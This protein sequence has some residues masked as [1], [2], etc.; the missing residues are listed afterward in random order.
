MTRPH[1]HVA[2]ASLNQTVGD[3]RGNAAR[4]V[5]A[6]DEAR[7]RGARLLVLPELCVSGYSLGDRVLRHGTLDQSWNTVEML[8]SHTTGM[9][10][11]VGLPVRHRGVLYNAVAVLA[12]GEIAGLAAKENLATGDV[13]YENRWYAGWPRGQVDT[14]TAPDGSPIPMGALVFDAPGLGRFAIEVCEDAWRGNRPASIY[15]L[16]GAEILINPSASW[17]VVGKHAARRR[18]VEQ[19]SAEDHAAYVFASLRGCDA[20]RLVFDGSVFI[21]IDGAIEQEA[22]RFRFGPGPTLIDRVIDL[23][24]LAKRRM[25]A[26]SWRQQ[27]DALHTGQLGTPPPT[28]LQVSGDYS[29][30]AP[31][32]PSPP[33]WVA[34]AAHVDPSLDWLHAEGMV[35]RP[36]EHADIPHIE[37]ELALATGLRD[38]LAKSGVKRVAL[39][40]SGGRD[41]TMVA[42]LVHRMLR[43]DNPELDPTAL[44]AHVGSTFT[45]VWMATDNSGAATRNAAA[46]TAAELGATHLAVDIQ[47]L[48]DRHLEVTEALTGTKLTWDEPSHDIPLQ[49]VQARLRGA[50]VWTAANLHNAILLTT[51]N[52]SEAAVGYATMDGD[53]SGGLAPIADVP[54]SLIVLW[55]RWARQMHGYTCVDQV[56][57]SPA[58]AELRPPDQAQTD[59]DDLMPFAVLDRLMFQFVQR[60]Q[61]P[62]DMFRTLWPEVQTA[63]GGD[64]RAF[65]AHIRRF[66]TLLCRAQWKRERFA[67]SFRVTAFDLDPKTGF[68]FPAVQAPFTEELAA[69]DAFVD[70]MAAPQ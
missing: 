56:L 20:T 23:E 67:I 49:N 63:Y 7:R 51:S 6:I 68:R 38:Y 60:G 52:K 31:S 17:F 24:R 16:G 40:L 48:L 35:T 28:I 69:L 27:V 15:A 45:T 57:A 61:D 9:V 70:R 2:A 33:Y 44:G 64:P 3:W 8:R 19:I 58:S 42:L 41:S 50:L 39:A 32:S 1:A 11:C 37:L 59:E 53:T 4:I 43:Y 65:A 47:A 36:L 25:T 5:E 14:F 54:K 26:G 34:P 29:T 12:N 13:E 10:V 46:A 66:V 22:E 30:A 55:L 21:A 18:M 62:I